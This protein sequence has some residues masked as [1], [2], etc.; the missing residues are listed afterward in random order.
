[1]VPRSV[2]IVARVLVPLAASFASVSKS[3]VPHTP[4]TLAA[5]VCALRL[6]RRCLKGLI[7]N[8]G[9]LKRYAARHVWTLDLRPVNPE[10]GL[11]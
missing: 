11:S 1:M 5:H 10:V 7:N 2:G 4:L 9:E 6:A 3:A 8:L